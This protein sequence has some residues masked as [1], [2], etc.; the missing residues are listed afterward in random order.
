[1]RHEHRQ[2]ASWQELGL[3]ESLSS[4]STEID[5]TYALD[6]AALGLVP[7]DRFIDTCIIQRFRIVP[8]FAAQ[9]GERDDLPSLLDDE[10]GL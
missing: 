6:F 1:M 4:R 7:R 10:L 9:L 8:R 2:G 3:D 5:S